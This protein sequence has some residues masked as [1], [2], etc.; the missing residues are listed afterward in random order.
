MHLSTDGQVKHHSLQRNLRTNGGAN[1]WNQQL[2]GSSGIQGQAN[3]P[4]Y[5]TKCRDLLADGV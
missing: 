4:S 5:M 1:F 3:T 2:F